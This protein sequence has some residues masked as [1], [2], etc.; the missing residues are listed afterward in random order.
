MLYLIVQVRGPQMG[1]LV[2]VIQGISDKSA[3]IPGSSLSSRIICRRDSYSCLK[4][5]CLKYNLAVASATSCSLSVN[6][7]E[8]DL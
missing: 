7:F 3:R 5:S 6:C 1:L 4:Y 2:M 8:S